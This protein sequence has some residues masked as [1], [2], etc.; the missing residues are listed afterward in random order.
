MKIFSVLTLIESSVLTI[1]NFL[2]FLSSEL[3]VVRVWS[4]NKTLHFRHG[5]MHASCLYWIAFST[6]LCRKVIFN[7]LLFFWYFRLPI[8]SS[9]CFLKLYIQRIFNM[10][11]YW[12]II[13]IWELLVLPFMESSL[14]IN[15]VLWLF[16]SS[17]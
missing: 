7:C 2:S 6:G 3:Q 8:N 12:G 11:K 15:W 16:L 5:K 10:F 17:L 1:S 13:Y 14:P 9:F 4:T